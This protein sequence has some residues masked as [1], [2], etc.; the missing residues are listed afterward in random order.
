MVSYE[1]RQAMANLQAQQ[2][3][4]IKQRLAPLPTDPNEINAKIQEY[5]KEYDTLSGDGVSLHGAQASRFTAV[6]NYLSDLKDAQGKSQ[7]AIQFENQRRTAELN[8]TLNTLHTVSNPGSAVGGGVLGAGSGS[9]R[10]VSTSKFEDQQRSGYY[11]GT[12]TLDSRVTDFFNPPPSAPTKSSGSSLPSS[13]TTKN[14][15]TFAKQ[16]GVRAGVKSIIPP[17]QNRELRGSTI[18]ARQLKQIQAGKLTEAQ[19]LSQNEARGQPST[20]I[21]TFESSK[22]LPQVAPSSSAFLSIPGITGAPNL[23]PQAF[24][25]VPP[26]DAQQTNEIQNTIDKIKQSGAKTVTI[27]TPSGKKQTVPVDQAFDFV[28][29]NRE[30]GTFNYQY[31]TGPSKKQQI[32][33]L[34]ITQGKIL[35]VIG[36]ARESGAKEITI[37]D[38]SGK[39]ITSPLNRAFYDITKASK[40]SPTLSFEY[41]GL[42]SEQRKINL[43]TLTNARKGISN[44]VSEARK[45]YADEITI[46][47]EDGTKTVVPIERANL[48][49][50]KATAGGKKVELSYEPTPPPITLVNVLE[51]RSRLKETPLYQP[52]LSGAKYIDTLLQLDQPVKRRSDAPFVIPGVNVVLPGISNRQIGYVSQ[53]L[54]NI[55]ATIY[56]AGKFVK[57]KAEFGPPEG[58]LNLPQQK[59]IPLQY[60]PFASPLFEGKAP[61]LSKK[62]VQSSLAGQVLLVGAT[63]GVAEGINVLSNLARGKP[64]GAKGGTGKGGSGPPKVTRSFELPESMRKPAG[65]P[66][67]SLNNLYTDTIKLEAPKPRGLKELPNEAKNVIKF[68]LDD[69][70][71]AGADK[72]A[73]RFN[74]KTGSIDKY[75]AQV[76]LGQ[77]KGFFT[78][79]KGS[80]SSGG[81]PSAPS[82]GGPTLKVKPDTTINAGKLLPPTVDV[83]SMSQYD[84]LGRAQPTVTF[85][86]TNIGLGRGSIDVKRLAGFAEANNR[87]VGKITDR[88]VVGNRRTYIEKLIDARKNSD[89]VEREPFKFYP[90]GSDYD[91]MPL[92]LSGR[93]DLGF[94]NLRYPLGMA[95]GSILVNLG[96]GKGSIVKGA[97][98]PRIKINFP[99]TS[100]TPYKPA[101]PSPRKGQPQLMQ[102]QATKQIQPIKLSALDALFERAGFQSTS[103]S[104]GKTQGKLVTRPMFS[105]TKI[106]LGK[107]QPKIPYAPGFRMDVMLKTVPPRTGRIVV[108]TPKLRTPVRTS[109]KIPQMSRAD[110]RTGILNIPI[111]DTTPTT[112][113]ITIPKFDTPQKR[114]TR[115]TTVPITGTPQTLITDLTFP[116]ETTTTGRG[117][118]RGGFFLPFGGG[119]GGVSRRGKRGSKKFVASEVDPL[120]AGVLLPDNVSELVGYTPKVFRQIDINLGR[121]RK[122]KGRTGGVDA[123]PFKGFSDK[124]LVRSNL[125]IGL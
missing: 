26:L 21:A 37:I 58:P 89:L 113:K 69:L 18:T 65:E 31:G 94:Q 5:Q 29:S 12:P 100:I 53:P 55:G 76:K 54:A 95:K 59:T 124:L 73:A 78:S 9:A 82:G 30:P 70:I 49:I 64:I 40:T 101:K 14:L 44:F 85:R 116:E 13:D 2:D 115:I 121:E 84:N 47:K 35:N 24:G 17:V 42:T 36:K 106:N 117:G 7:Q 105:A 119:T 97:P 102:K 38:S 83:L 77:G 93:I 68:K 61:D 81:G 108:S 122:R 48:E 67:R 90:K 22:I 88:P 96:K 109:L 112:G 125:G 10:V 104:L 32:G 34:K 80:G 15:T 72:A 71:K 120:R 50:N 62:E 43:D 60:E 66:M 114:K 19:A 75:V 28:N 107:A 16:P 27:T 99:T 25:E 111:V 87:I 79:G 110:E 41:G 92:D 3:A 23:L 56:D 8:N 52:L 51:S 118:G 86:S 4:E 6:S 98:E 20:G 74:P 123:E 91:V 103:V 39:K 1:F 63:S 46:T 33:N 45:N 57:G 11:S